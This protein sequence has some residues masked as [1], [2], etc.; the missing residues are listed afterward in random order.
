MRRLTCKTF[1]TSTSE[2]KG[3][4]YTNTHEVPGRV[5]LTNVWP[6]GGQDASSYGNVKYLE[7]KDADSS[8]DVLLKIPYQI[9]GYGQVHNNHSLGVGGIL[10]PNG[11]HL[12]LGNP[13]SSVQDF[14]GC[15]LLYELG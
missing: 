14:G 8:G 1:T 4:P 5:L 13:S 15:T 7:F 3:G 12:T 6:I 11:L 9:S 2:A 10:F